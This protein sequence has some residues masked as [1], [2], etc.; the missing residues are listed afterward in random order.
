MRAPIALIFEIYVVHTWVLGNPKRFYIIFPD[1]GDLV[2]HFQPL[3]PYF[4][5]EIRE[6]QDYNGVIK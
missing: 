2:F 4:L 5:H 1:L 6:R 3:N